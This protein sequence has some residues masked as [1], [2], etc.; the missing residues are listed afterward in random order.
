MFHKSALAKV[1]AATAV[2]KTSRVVAVLLIVFFMI[3]IFLPLPL[4]GSY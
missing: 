4:K 3:F 1:G 2:F